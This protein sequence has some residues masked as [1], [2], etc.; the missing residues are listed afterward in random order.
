MSNLNLGIKR[1]RRLQIIDS[2]L[3]HHPKGSAAALERDALLPLLSVGERM[4]FLALQLISWPI[5]LLPPR[6]LAAFAFRMK[7]LMGQYNTGEGRRP[8]SMKPRNMTEALAGLR[9]LP[10]DQQP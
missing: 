5:S 10:K 9:D 8:L 2:G 7:C 6:W 4:L 1:Y 3:T